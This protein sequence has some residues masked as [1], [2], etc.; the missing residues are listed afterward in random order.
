[1]STMSDTQSI[2]P[3]LFDVAELPGRP[4]LH[5]HGKRPLREIPYYPAQLR[6]RYGHAPSPSQGEG[7][8]E[9]GWVNRLYWGDNLQVM[10]HLMRKFRGQVKLIYIDPPF[11]SGADYRKR[12]KL[13]G[14]SVETDLSVLEERQYTD[15]WSNDL[16]LQ[17][18]YERLILMRELLAEDGSIFLHCDWHRGHLLRCILDEVFGFDNFRNE[19]VV[20][21]RVKKNLQRQFELVQSLPHG[22]DAVLWYSKGP[23]ARFKPAEMEVKTR[24]EGYWHHFWSNADRPSMRYELLGITPSDGQWKWNRERALQAAKNYERYLQE[25]KGMSLVE[26]WEKTGR[27]LEF[28]RLSESGKVENWYPPATTRIADTLWLDVHAYENIKDYPT[29]KHEQ[30]LDRIIEMASDPGDLVADFFIGSGTT[31]AVAQKLGRRW[32]GA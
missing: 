5:W 22:H 30:L 29:Q 11:D 24:K 6:E 25:G 8:G 14:T 27:R 15:I 21:R 4:M 26:Y 31:A 23:S 19:L 1:M 9:G 20:K 28:I 3:Q 17:Y 32:I 7:R 16:Y 2:Q 13:R 10:A 18:M 12:I